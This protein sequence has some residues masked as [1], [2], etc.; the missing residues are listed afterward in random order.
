M[1]IAQASTRISI[2][3]ASAAPVDA[4]A[5]LLLPLMSGTAKATLLLLLSVVCGYAFFVTRQLSERLSPP[6]PHELFAIVNEQLAAFRSADFDSAYR[7]AA[8][9]VQQKFTVRQFEEMVRRD[10]P[11]MTRAKRVEFGVVRVQ[12]ASAIVQVFFFA[13]NGTV[14]SFIYSLTNENN[15]WKIDGVKELKRLGPNE[16]LAG[17]HV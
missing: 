5:R 14:R 1:D 17:S 10:Y 6:P 7:H 15:A 16:R 3:G 12:G 2:C 4:A 11:E 8:T 13:G 9:G